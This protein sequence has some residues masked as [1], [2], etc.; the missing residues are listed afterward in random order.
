MKNILTNITLAI[1]F[2]LL[3]Y[4]P[5]SIYRFDDIKDIASDDKVLSAKSDSLGRYIS[6]GE[7]EKVK[8]YE[9]AVFKVFLDKNVEYTDFYSITNDSKLTKEYKVLA[10]NYNGNTGFN[11]RFTST[12]TDHVLVKPNETVGLSV[13][14]QPSNTQ[15][16]TLS[17]LVL[18]KP[19][20]P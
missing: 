18:E 16:T 6:F 14:F 17:F 9:T 12:G 10:V 15:N 13:T 5:F 1:V 4:L 7:K 8:T 19:L 2:S 3:A 11:L 20:Y